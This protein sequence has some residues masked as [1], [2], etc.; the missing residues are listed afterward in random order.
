MDKMMSSKVGSVAV[1]LAAG[2]GAAFGGRQGASGMSM[3]LQAIQQQQQLQEQQRIGE[4][5]A[6][7]FEA[8]DTTATD[9]T[10]ANRQNPSPSEIDGLRRMGQFF[11]RS[12][13]TQS[14]LRVMKQISDIS[15]PI[16]VDGSL[17][18][19]TG[20]V[21]GSAPV[22]DP[23]RIQGSGNQVINQ[24]DGTVQTTPWTE[25]EGQ[26]LSALAGSRMAVDESRIGANEALVGQRNAQADLAASKAEN[27]VKS[28]GSEKSADPIVQKAKLAETMKK[29]QDVLDMGDMDQGQREVLRQWLESLANEWSALDEATG[30]GED[31]E[32]TAEEAG[33]DLI[34]SHNDTMQGKVYNFDGTKLVPAG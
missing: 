15:S 31:D 28:G 34:A 24:A 4:L 23:Y 7:E 13:D 32:R 8:P 9:S 11:A 6:K 3:A 26:R 17:M 27:L 22:R 33:I 25:F 14:A 2:A 5:F 10:I 29:I 16:E 20:D 12:G 21:L 1:P 30:K 18:S 19:R